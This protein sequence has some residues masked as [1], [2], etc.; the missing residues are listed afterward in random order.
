M[1]RQ[2]EQ[3]HRPVDKIYSSRSYY[4]EEDNIQVFPAK[5]FGS[6]LKQSSSSI[7]SPSISVLSLGKVF[8]FLLCKK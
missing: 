6:L 3:Q 5:D 4:D 2:W 1:L 8:S 7:N